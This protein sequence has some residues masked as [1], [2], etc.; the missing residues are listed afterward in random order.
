MAKYEFAEV[1]PFFVSTSALPGACEWKPITNQAG[2]DALIGNKGIVRCST[3]LNADCPRAGK[4]PS[5][6]KKYFFCWARICNSYYEGGE[7][8]KYLHC[9]KRHAILIR[10][11]S[12]IAI[13]IAVLDCDSKRDKF[14][15]TAL[16]SFR[17][18]ILWEGVEPLRGGVL[19]ISHVSDSIR[20]TLENNNRASELSKISWHFQGKKVTKSKTLIKKT[21]IKKTLIKKTLIKK[22][23]IK[24]S[25]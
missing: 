3:E 24:K 16:D 18:D 7:V 17:G 25:R 10:E 15:I 1:N 20:S 13:D 8:V 11:A 6:P 12:E 19:K 21:L 14:R 2:K 4:Y 22:A 23:L 9:S 5:M